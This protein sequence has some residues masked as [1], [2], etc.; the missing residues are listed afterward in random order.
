MKASA[1]HSVHQALEHAGLDIILGEREF[2]FAKATEVRSALV[3]GEV[4]GGKV[5]GGEGEGLAQVAAEFG[6]GL[7]R[8]TEDEIEREVG[9]AE[10]AHQFERPSSRCGVVNAAKFV[11]K[12]VVEALCANADTV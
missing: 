6:E 8:A 11:E 12:A 2:A 7:A 9:D 5:L 3:N 10:V 1:F 4:I